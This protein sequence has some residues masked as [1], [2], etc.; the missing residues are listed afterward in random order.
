MLA[1]TLDARGRFDEARHWH[2]QALDSAR[3]QAAPYLLSEV[4]SFYAW[5]LNTTGQPREAEH[6]SREGLSLETSDNSGYLRNSLAQALLQGRVDGALEQL[7]PQLQA[8]NLTLAAVAHAR[9]ART[10]HRMGQQATARQALEDGA[11]LLLLTEA[12]HPRYEWA[13][14]ALTIAPAS[15]VHG[16]PRWCAASR[17]M[18]TRLFNSSGNSPQ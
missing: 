1:S 11:A 4:M 3:A 9:Q 8:P 6:V 2:R 10:L 12:G 18:M 16:P 13:V 15:T 5:H 14:T 7:A 17:R